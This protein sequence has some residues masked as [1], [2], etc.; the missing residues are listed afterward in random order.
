V[1]E[2]RLRKLVLYE[3]ADGKCPWQEWFDGLE[4]GKARAAIDARLQRLQL[5]NLGDHRGLGEGVSELRVH[6]GPGY[7]IY[8]GQDGDVLVV[9]L[10]G[11]SKRL[12]RR[13]IQRAKTYWR[14]YRGK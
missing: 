1:I 4:D 3:T 7:R 11:G 13:D 8:F 5:G 6:A 12:Q 10:C 14:R 2:P 9:L